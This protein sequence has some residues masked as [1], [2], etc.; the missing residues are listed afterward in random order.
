MDNEIKIQEI[1]D[2]YNEN[3]KWVVKKYKNLYYINQ[4]IDDKLVNDKF[5]KLEKK[6]IIEVLSESLK[7]ANDSLI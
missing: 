3:K 1:Q 7:F 4:K 5:Q 6:Y 2:K